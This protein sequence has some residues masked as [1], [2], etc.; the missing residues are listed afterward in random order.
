MKKHQTD[1]WHYVDIHVHTP[2]SDDYQG[3]KSKDEFS[4][5]LDKAL[6]ISSNSKTDISVS[7]KLSLIAITDH[8]SVEGYKTIMAQRAENVDLLHRLKRRNSSSDIIKELQDEEDKYS[9]IH[10]LMGVE[11]SPDPGIH[12]LVIFK[13][14]VKPE[15]VETFLTEGIGSPYESFRGD[16]TPCL[17]WNISQAMDQIEQRFGDKAIVVAP[18]A[19]SS[20]GLYESLKGL[21]H[22]RMAAFK[23]PKLVAVCFNN[24]DNRGKMKLMLQSKDYERDK[25][26]AFIQASDYHGLLSNDIGSSFTKLQFG[27]NKVNFSSLCNS[28]ANEEN[29][30]CFSDIIIDVYKEAVREWDIAKICVNVKPEINETDYRIISDTACAFLNSEGGIIEISVTNINIDKRS[31]IVKLCVDQLQA[32]ITD[33]VKPGL[34][35][36]IIKSI[37]LSNTKIIILFYI[38]RSNRL[39]SSE[40]RV[41]VYDK[42]PRE[43][44][45]SEIEYTVTKNICN[46]FDKSTDLEE[47]SKEAN[48]LSKTYRAYPIAI[49]MQD[50]ICFELKSLCTI[51]KSEPS[52]EPTDE[53]KA[54]VKDVPNGFSNG[55]L[56]VCPDR[57]QEPRF[58]TSYYRFSPRRYDCE[59][60]EGCNLIANDGILVLRGGGSH[61][62]KG[63]T[64][65]VCPF[66]T[67]CL[68]PIDPSM[69]LC[70]LGWFKSSLFLWYSAI[71]NGDSDLYL[72][73]GFNPKSV[74]IPTNGILDNLKEQMTLIS[75]DII[76]KENQFLQETYAITD[77]AELN[78]KIDKFNIS[79]NE[80][81]ILLDNLVFDQ[82]RFS[83]AERNE[84]YAALKDI[85]FYHFDAIN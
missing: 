78:D 59:I 14:D 15:D 85:G 16:P 19:D 63:D 43:A 30:I 17:R 24:A 67:I 40:G 74:P 50:S 3:P 75:N 46:R 65:L 2:A 42:A 9:R 31:E 62:V 58:D 55:N 7:N 51:I 23:H 21:P 39:H 68:V 52:S 5:I 47:M 60:Y 61:F 28:L 71:V 1:G 38:K 69:A 33:R 8:N 72:C 10:I 13:E 18:H 82:F 22:P 44:T 12:L 79:I 49:R 6:S 70:Y 84:V 64:G 41:Y 27:S 54:Y 56:I 37:P 35:K 32:I 25:P 80:Y 76:S 73:T 4:N 29:V 53:I 11:I 81:M 57:R 48:I 26:L 83:K 34:G 77:H 45:I 20:K 66:P 36:T